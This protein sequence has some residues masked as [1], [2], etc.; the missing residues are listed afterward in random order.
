MARARLT[1]VESPY[2][3]AAAVLAHVK[4]A[5]V[6]CESPPITTEYVAVGE[7]VWDDCCGQ[8]V[9]GVERSF[10]TV[11]PFPTEAGPDGL[12]AGTPIAVEIVVVLVR[13]APTLSDS[14]KA[15]SAAKLDASSQSIYRD[16]AIVWNALASAELLGDDGFGD[17][18]WERSGLQQT[19]DGEGGCVG[20]ETRV[21]LGIPSHLW[22]TNCPPAVV[23]PPDDEE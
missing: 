9:V 19:F 3:V 11:A 8:L 1:V 22:C 21:T 14:G 5:L 20:I 7:A 23:F 10:R 6:A 13:C 2:T 18:E 4:D 16:A 17:T 15:P 12:C